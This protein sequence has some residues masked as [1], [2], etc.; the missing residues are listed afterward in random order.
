MTLL[1]GISIVEDISTITALG[2]IESVAEQSVSGLAEG[3][4]PMLSEYEILLFLG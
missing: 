1:L 2:I 4:G 3:N